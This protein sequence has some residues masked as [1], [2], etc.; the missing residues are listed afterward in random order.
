MTSGGNNFSDSAEI[1]P[2]G[3]IAITTEKTVLVLSSVAVDLFHEW[4]QCSSSSS[5]RVSPALRGVRDAAS[6]RAGRCT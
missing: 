5:T 6:G 3:E 2:T 1:V 4:A